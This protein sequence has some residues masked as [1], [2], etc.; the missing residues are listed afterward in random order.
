MHR[1]P[2]A[3]SPYDR[4]LDDALLFDVLL[5][6]PWHAGA[7]SQGRRGRILPR[8]PQM[9]RS[10]SSNSSLSPPRTRSCARLRIISTC[11][12]LA[13]SSKLS[14]RKVHLGASAAFR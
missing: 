8:T 14:C 2:H 12:S 4:S 6:D 5:N 1:S 11:C 7:D 9:A 10:N 13:A 3:P